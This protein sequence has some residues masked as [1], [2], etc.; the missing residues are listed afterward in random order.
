MSKKKKIE[1]KDKEKT[2]QP[3]RT[4]KPQDQE[5]PFDFGGLPLRDMKKNLGCG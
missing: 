2:K 5:K 1:E 3:V 4:E